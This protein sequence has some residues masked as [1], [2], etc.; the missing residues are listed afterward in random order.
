MN[1]TAPHDD[2][3]LFGPES[4]TWR[5]HMEPVLWVGGFR[6]LLLQSLHPRVMRGTYQNSAL[7]DPRKAWPRFQRTVE[8]VEVRTFGSTAQVEA[9]AARVRRLHAAL[10]AYDPD[11]NA[12]FALDEPSGLLFVHCA[13]I[14]SYADIARRAGILDDAGIERYLAESV[15]AARVVGLTAAPASS[16]QMRAYFERVRPELRLTDEARQATGNLLAPKGSAPRGVKFAITAVASMA[17]ATLPRWA[18]RLYGLPGLPTT[19]LSMA[20]TLRGLRA[21]TS[22]L[23]DAPASPE[24][25]RARRLMRQSRQGGECAASPARSIPRSG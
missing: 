17:L 16:A 25:E 24:V 1:G 8:F 22:L 3:G 10:H 5:V 18:R 21:A 14:D 9:A 19:D 20:M 11:T 7:F 12:T 13:E 15:R 4:V 6:A 23:P 2:D